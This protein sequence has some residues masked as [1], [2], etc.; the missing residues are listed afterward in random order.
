VFTDDRH[1]AGD[2][3]RGQE[4][5]WDPLLALAPNEIDDFMWMFE[6]ELE[7]GLRLHAFKHVETASLECCRLGWSK[8]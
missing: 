4:P 6:V 1:I 5:N 2:S 8:W 7:S 3:T